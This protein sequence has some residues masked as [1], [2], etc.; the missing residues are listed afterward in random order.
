MALLSFV[1]HFKENLK[2]FVCDFFKGS[3]WFLVIYCNK[4]FFKPINNI[5]N[6]SFSSIFKILE[7]AVRPHKIISKNKRKA[8][9]LKYYSMYRNIYVYI[10]RKSHFQT[11][12][13]QL[14]I[15]P[16]YIFFAKT[17]LHSAAENIARVYIL[18]IRDARKLYP[19]SRTNSHPISENKKKGFLYWEWK[20]YK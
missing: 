8:I 12:K 9:L 14:A 15:Q 17:A 5:Q 19:N 6:G 4:N 7:G 11:H 3:K 2:V 16:M 13:Y 10:K 18:W 1:V 20:H